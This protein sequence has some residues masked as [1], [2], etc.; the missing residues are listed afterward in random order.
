MASYN[1]KSI[2]PVPSNKDFVD[3][4]LTRTQRKTPTQVHSSWNIQR[5][6]AFYMR[7]VKYTQTT[8]HEKLEQI[9]NDF[10][11]LD[12]IHPFYTDLINVLYDRDHYKL[13]LGQINTARQIIDNISKDY[14]RLLKYGDSLFRCKQLKRAALGRMCTVMRGQGPT[15]AYLEEVRKH[16]SRLPSIDPNTRTLIV[17]GYP[18][19]GKSSF[20]NKVTRADVDVQ[21]YAFTTKSLFVGHMDYKYTRWQ[22]IDTPGILD[23]PLE[24]RNTIEM[25][26]ITALAHLRAAVLFFLDISEQCGYTIEQQVSL[27]SNISPLFANKPLMVVATKI[28]AQPWETLDEENKAKIQNIVE[29]SGA[30]F[31]TMSNFTDE[32]IMDVKTRACDALLEKRVAEKLKSRKVGD[33]LNRLSVT[34]P[35][36]RDNRQRTVEIPDSVKAALEAKSELA[37]KQAE[38]DARRNRGEYVDSDDDEDGDGDVEMGGSHPMIRKWL[39]RDKE[40]YGGGPGVYRADMTKYYLLRDDEW[41]TDMVPEIMDG[42]NIADYVDPDILE[43]L[44]ALEAEEEGLLAAYEAEKAAEPVVSSD[45]E[46]TKELYEEIMARKSIIIQ[47]HRETKNKNRPV[48]P[49]GKGKLPTKEDF[50]KGLASTGLPEDIAAA[51]AESAAKKGPD[52]TSTHRRKRTASEAGLDDVMDEDGDD[53]GIAGETDVP[54]KGLGV[55]GSSLPTRGR[56]LVRSDDGLDPEVRTTRAR[57][58]A[59]ARA[60]VIAAKYGDERTFKKARMLKSREPKEI[61]PVAK[62]YKNEKEYER[63]S[64]EYKKFRSL[65]F[66]GRKG[67]GDRTQSASMPKWLNTGKMG[68]SRDWR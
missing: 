44:M 12:E 1:F 54:V 15:L 13:A 68:F 53:L 58:A 42:K 57:S 33:V 16:L 25:Q 45:D 10:P 19:V 49:R 9:L 21:P 47:R 4:V 23:H 18:N 51:A 26:S 62:G 30:L 34:M 20:M 39:E 27:F 17:C 38:R 64:K 59:K 5:I 66:D 60:Q 52:T 56:T 11:K 14:V 29:K 63:A 22:V 31:T 40:R 67:E 28:D 41:K 3:I 24:E 2:H 43:R 6:R 36:P 35:K 48:L 50:A 55:P 7:K 61:D 32:G 65:K 46:E 37:A 8:F